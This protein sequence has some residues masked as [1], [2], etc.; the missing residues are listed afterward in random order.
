[1]SDEL[2]MSVSPICT[3]DGRKYAFVSFTDGE[4]SAEGR[5][6]ECR[7]TVNGGFDRE[8]VIQLEEYMSRELPQLKKMAAG[9]NIM[10]NFM[11]GTKT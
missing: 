8:E 7:I 9:I 1:M 6:P 4:R 3:K 2:R 11:D 10:R 5:I